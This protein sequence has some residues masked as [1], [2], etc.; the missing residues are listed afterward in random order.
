MNILHYLYVKGE[1]A[2]PLGGRGLIIWP[3][4]LLMIFYILRLMIKNGISGDIFALSVLCLY[5]ILLG[6]TYIILPRKKAKNC[7]D[8]WKNKYGGAKGLW[9]KLYVISPIIIF[10]VALIY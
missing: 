5:G 3:V 4:W 2:F 10:F 6:I 9:A 8:S 7:L 1:S